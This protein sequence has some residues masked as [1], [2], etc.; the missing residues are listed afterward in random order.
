M[1]K[2]FIFDLDGTLLDSMHVWENVGYNFLKSLGIEEPPREINDTLRPMGVKESAQYL[3]DTFGFPQTP[4]EL[5]CDLNKQMERQY[6]DTIELKEGALAFLQK[7]EGRAMCVATA[8][9]RDLVEPALERL[10]IAHFFEFILTSYEVGNSKHEPDIYLQS[11]QKLGRCAEDCIVFEDALH[12]ASTAKKAG[13]YVVGVHETCFKNDHA[14]MSALCDEWVAD[15][16]ECTA[17]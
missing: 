9:R 10:G 16:R 7:N 11:A 14:E 1:D 15:L 13:F 5:I 2:A 17:F 12:A 6:K 4:E 8:T 3:C